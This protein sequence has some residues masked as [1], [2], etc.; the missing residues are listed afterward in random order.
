MFN[1][2][3]LCLPYEI[4]IGNPNLSSILCSRHCNC[5]LVLND[6]QNQNQSYGRVREIH[7]S[8][9]GI[10]DLDLRKFTYTYAT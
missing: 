6:I 3:L 5:F 4:F 7:V 8:L 9:R 10:P 1:K 2:C